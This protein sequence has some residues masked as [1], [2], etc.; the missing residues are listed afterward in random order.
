[1]SDWRKKVDDYR[2]RKEEEA[3]RRADK[4]SEREAN[5]SLSSYDRQLFFHKLKFKCCVC[6]KSSAGPYD[7]GPGYS[8]REGTDYHSHSYDWSRPGDMEQCER[9][10]RW[11]CSETHI[12]RGI[13]KSCASRR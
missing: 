12:Y 5:K 11:A 4:Q 8:G 10:H 1:M 6:G 13:C 2:T 9:C 3:R 7:H